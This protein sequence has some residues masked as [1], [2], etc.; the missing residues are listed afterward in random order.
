MGRENDSFASPRD[1]RQISADYAEEA[2][3]ADTRGEANPKSAQAE[4]TS[5]EV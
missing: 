2:R 4:G 3:A 1:E 5:H